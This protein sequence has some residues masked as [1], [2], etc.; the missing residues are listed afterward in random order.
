MLRFTLLISVTY[1][2]CYRGTLPVTL[3]AE[4]LQVLEHEVFWVTF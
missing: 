1:V 2:F 4:Q 3:Q